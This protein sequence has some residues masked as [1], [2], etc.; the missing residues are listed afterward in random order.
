MIDH[1]L[2]EGSLAET[3]KSIVFIK[4]ISWNCVKYICVYRNVDHI[5]WYDVMQNSNDIYNFWKKCCCE[6]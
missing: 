6:L 4:S 1:F 3:L 5:K 2:K